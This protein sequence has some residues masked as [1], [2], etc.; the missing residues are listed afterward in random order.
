MNKRRLQKLK[1]NAIK[2]AY[3]SEGTGMGNYRIGAVLANK[4]GIDLVF[5][6]VDAYIIFDNK[7]YPIK[8]KSVFT[9]GEELNLE[10]DSSDV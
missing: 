7:V 9:V 2:M 5:D 8:K 4:K 10:G 3:E 6:K 1:E